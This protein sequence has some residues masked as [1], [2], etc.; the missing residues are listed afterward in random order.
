LV[1]NAENKGVSVVAYPY[2]FAKNRKN[3]TKSRALK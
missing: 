1:A 2:F 3:E